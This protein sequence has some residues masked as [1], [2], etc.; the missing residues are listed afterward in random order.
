MVLFSTHERKEQRRAQR[1]RVGERVGREMVEEERN[2]Y[3]A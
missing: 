1:G 2:A 3:G